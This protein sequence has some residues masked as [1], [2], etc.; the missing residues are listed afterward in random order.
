MIGNVDDQRHSDEGEGQAE[1]A[2]T[3][4]SGRPVLWPRSRRPLFRIWTFGAAARRVKRVKMISLCCAAG[5]VLVARINSAMP[6]L[7]ETPAVALSCS[8][9]LGGSTIRL[10][11]R[12]RAGLG[13]WKDPGRG[14][15]VP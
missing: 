1:R 7:M 4:R 14:V 6:R 8:C 9:T 15:R 5:P 3:R 13:W 12:A 11:I 2:P 10:W